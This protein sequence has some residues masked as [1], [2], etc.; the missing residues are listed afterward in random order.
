MLIITER[1]MGDAM[2]DF[3]DKDE[4]DSLQ[5]VFTHQLDRCKTR[6]KVRKNLIRFKSFS[7]NFYIVYR[8]YSSQFLNLAKKFIERRRN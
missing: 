3:V 8:V 7:D 2:K 5:E 6:L 4:K 1:G